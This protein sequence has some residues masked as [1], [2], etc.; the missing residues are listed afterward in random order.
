[1]SGW[2]EAGLPPRVARMVAQADAR[3]AVEAKRAQAER[4]AR[5]EAVHAEV[6]EFYRQQAEA[7]GEDIT[8]LEVA[9]G[10]VSGR[11]LADIS[12]TRS[13][14]GISRTRSRRRGRPGKLEAGRCPCLLANRFCM[15]LRGRGAR[16][17]SGCSIRTGTG[18]SCA[19]R[20]SVWMRPRTASPAT[21]A[22]SVTRRRVGRVRSS[23]SARVTAGLLGVS[24]G[25]D[26]GG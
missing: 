12:P 19:R 11:S 26:P 4:E 22:S 10:R 24:S 17:A 6:V 21:T 7:R 20:A 25:D 2:D 23:S 16:S 18:R 15:R 3:E 14:P 13:R 5:N 9:T 1:M 8:A